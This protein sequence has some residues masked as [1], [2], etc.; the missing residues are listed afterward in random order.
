VR[1]NYKYYNSTLEKEH[2]R[3]THG[4]NIYLRGIKS[5]NLLSSGGKVEEIK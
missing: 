1:E 5:S 3:R 2:M 4:M